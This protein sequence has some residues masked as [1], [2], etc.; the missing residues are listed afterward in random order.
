MPIY[1]F[2]LVGWAWDSEQHKIK[3]TYLYLC[4]Y[5]FWMS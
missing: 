5:S 3:V 2:S 1:K 4:V